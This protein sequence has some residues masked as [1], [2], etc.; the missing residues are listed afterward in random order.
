M[1]KWSL[2]E[3]ELKTLIELFRRILAAGE[4]VRE[5]ETV[6]MTAQERWAPYGVQKCTEALPPKLTTFL[7]QFGWRRTM[8]I[9][10]PELVGVLGD[11]GLKLD[12]SQM[13]LVLAASAFWIDM[14]DQSAFQNAKALSAIEEFTLFV[15]AY[16]QSFPA[17]FI[18]SREGDTLNKQFRALQRRRY[19]YDSMVRTPSALVK[20]LPMEARELI[21]SYAD[22]LLYGIKGASDALTAT[23]AVAI[24]RPVDMTIVQQ[25][26]VALAAG[27]V[28]QHAGEFAEGPGMHPLLGVKNDDYGQEWDLANESITRALATISSLKSASGS[29]PTFAQT[30]SRIPVADVPLDARSL[31]A[32]QRFND[33]VSMFAV[34]INNKSANYEPEARLVAFDAAFKGGNATPVR[35]GQEI[36]ALLPPSSVKVIAR[37]KALQDRGINDSQIASEF[38]T[39]LGDRANTMQCLEALEVG[40]AWMRGELSQLEN[41]GVRGER[42]SVKPQAYSKRN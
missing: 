24:G 42:V 20:R 39:A 15:N 14:G 41:V 28:W 9:K 35:S 5:P 31:A 17:R 27:M 4:A 29:D 25:I 6:G 3:T 34:W 11:L 12:E 33:Y 8:H 7:E 26:K 10:I 32:L 13:R 37:F 36:L 21:D 1:P 2:S 23:V 18:P 30:P 22:A 38:A 16:A 19:G 40:A